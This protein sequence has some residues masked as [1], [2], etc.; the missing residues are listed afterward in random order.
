[1]I[2]PEQWLEIGV[3]IAR[4]TGWTWDYIGELPVAKLVSIYSELI[5]QESVDKWESNRNLAEVLAAV[6]NTIPRQKGSKTFSAKDFYDTQQ[7]SRDGVGK[8]EMD[9]VDSMADAIGI[10]LPKEK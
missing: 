6:Y 7:P 10:Q 3:Y 8:V 9:E 2:A 1:M 5:F 4:K